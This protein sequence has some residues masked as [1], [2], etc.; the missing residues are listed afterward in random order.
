MSSAGS[1]NNII[2]GTFLLAGVVLAVWG[3]FVLGGRTD[4]AG[5]TP[6][7]FRFSLMDGAAGIQPGSPVH[8]GGQEVGLVERV[9]PVTTMDGEGNDLP[10]GWDLHVRVRAE[11]PIFANA[12]VTLERPLLGSLSSVNIVSV[13]GP[14]QPGEARTRLEEGGMVRGLPAPPAFLAQAGFGPEQRDQIQK[15]IADAEAAVAS[16]RRMIDEGGP[17]LQESVEELEAMIEAAREKWPEWLARVDGLT[18]DLRDGGARVASVMDEAEA[19]VKE[20][21]AAAASMR[22]AIDENR[23]QLDTIV[24]NADKATARLAGPTIDELEKGIAEVER[25]LTDFRALVGDAGDVL[26][27]QTPNIRKAMANLRLMSDQLRLVA[28]EVRSQPWRLLVRPDTKEL[29]QQLLYD[30][31][32]SYAAAVSDLR[33]VSESL[34]AMSKRTTPATEADRAALAELQA[35]LRDAFTEYQQR[36]REMLDRLIKGR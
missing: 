22:A 9:A 28:V 20:A 33:A 11:V 21:R 18:S 34:E 6:Y 4:T 19:T 13:G 23:P 25:T 35:R 10:T 31:A 36:E 5:T 3:S 29:E 17:K 30:S 26:A 7:R 15:I 14:E 12:I 2:A 24:D 32:R 8:M 16:V 1:K 27:E